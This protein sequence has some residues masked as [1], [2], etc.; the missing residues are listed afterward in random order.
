MT[1]R[2]SKLILLLALAA[3]A[4]PAGATD[5]AKAT[6][7]VVTSG[8]WS[9][10][11]PLGLQAGSAYI[12]DDNLMSDDKIAL[13]K[14]LYF[15]KRISKDG[16]LACASCH[17][18]FHGF[19]DPERTSA[20]VVG[21]PGTRNSPTVINRLFSAD[22]FWDGR[23]KDLEAQ[24]HGPITNPIE[25]AMGSEAEAVERVRAVKGYAPLFA[26]A[27]GDDAIDMDR[28]TKAIAAYERT[29]VSGDS[30]YDRYQA[31]DKDALSPAAVRGMALFNGKANCV[32]CHAGFNF[33]D[34]NYNNLG[35][36]M[37]RPKPDLGRYEVTKKDEDRGKFKTP[38]LRNVTETAPYMHDGSE[39]TLAQ[40]IDL[41][42]RGGVKN[43]N[44]S[45]EMKPLGL[46]A[47]EKRELL[48]FLTSLTGEVR[49]ADPP[50]ELPR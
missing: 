13:G 22:Q 27:F 20:G 12:P 3:C 8:K 18:P 38:T 16:T 4:A 39:A 9:M 32:R 31:G 26:K 47:A 44:L 28:I 10:T 25:M 45:K 1:T 41:Y 6:S 5:A 34:E 33:T 46:S 37:D 50:A 42:D 14:L 40:V 35:V 15:D 21:K 43:P 19:A 11:L 30:P 17:N 36:G 49:N 23:A 24:A 2:A 7:E 48:A 29:V